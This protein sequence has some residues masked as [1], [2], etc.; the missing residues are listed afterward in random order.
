[1]ARNQHRHARDCPVCGERY[2]CTTLGFRWI[3]ETDGRAVLA[4]VVRAGHYR[5]VTQTDVHLI[6]HVRSGDAEPTD[7]RIRVHAGPK[8]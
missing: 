8:G 4:S 1:M 5:G 7:N 2:I 3:S 6:T